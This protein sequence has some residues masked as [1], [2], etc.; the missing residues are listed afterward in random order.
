ME[1]SI[2]MWAVLVSG[3]ASFILGFV[4]YGPLFGKQ[5]MRMQGTTP[6]EANRMM[7][8]PK[9]KNK[10]MLNYAFTFILALV[11]VFVLAHGIIFTE[12]YFVTS[13]ITCG[14]AV[15]VFAWLGFFVPATTN[16]VFFDKKKWDW[17]FLVNGYYLI[18]LIL[19][20]TILSLWM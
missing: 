7:Q 4:W 13:G 3:V 16:L 6:E 19:I 1:I 14:I 15:A 5:Y 11:T 12:A 9:F 20:G 8:D 17:W 18:Q 10:M 2:N